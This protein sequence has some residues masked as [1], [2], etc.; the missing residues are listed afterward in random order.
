MFD[1]AVSS[2]DQLPSEFD[3]VTAEIQYPPITKE[4][5]EKEFVRRAGNG[6]MTWVVGFSAAGVVGFGLFVWAMY[7]ISKWL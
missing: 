7:E 6:Y 5:T 3:E 2:Q 4:T 1:G